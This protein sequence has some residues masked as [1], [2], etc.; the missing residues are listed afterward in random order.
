MCIRFSLESV[1][2][3]GRV[4]AGVKGITLDSD[5]ELIWFSQLNPKD[6][7]V[8]FSDR[9][10]GKRI[11]ENDFEQQNR[12]GK[13]VHCFNFNKNGSNGRSLAGVYLT[14]EQSTCDLIVTQVRSPATKISKDEILMQGK[15]GKGMPYIM[16]ILDDIITGVDG[17]ETVT[18]NNP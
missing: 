14:S 7:L 13:G 18:N 8:L 10:W 1:P 5:D 17:V 16:A 4:A 9:G 6:E 11:P 2:V 3:Q 15:S 12:G